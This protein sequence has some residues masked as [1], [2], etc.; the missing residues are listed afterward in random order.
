MS[1]KKQNWNTRNPV[2]R[3]QKVDNEGNP[4][5]RIPTS[6]YLDIRMKQ[7]ITKKSGNLSEW[8][9]KMIRSAYKHEYCF[10]CF[11]DNVKE[12]RHGWVC[13]NEKHRNIAGYGA[14]SVVL[15]WKICSF[16][17]MDY[18]QNNMPSEIDNDGQRITLCDNCAKATLENQED[19]DEPMEE[20]IGDGPE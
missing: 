6:I 11:D 20:A 16:C 19:K 18:N 4:I 10:W 14:P 12:V 7:W 9:E 13:A 1:E 5:Y 2:G 17:D 3:P 8:I 15:D